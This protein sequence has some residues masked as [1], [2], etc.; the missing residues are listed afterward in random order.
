MSM[1]RNTEKLAWWR[2]GQLSTRAAVTIGVAK[3]LQYLV[4]LRGT[5]E[6]RELDTIP[7]HVQHG[8]QEIADERD[9]P[10]LAKNTMIVFVPEWFRYSD[11]SKH[12]AHEVQL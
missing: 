4:Q 2:A 5:L 10:V 11:W 8:Y 9:N 7:E 3:G 6:V 1:G 12:E